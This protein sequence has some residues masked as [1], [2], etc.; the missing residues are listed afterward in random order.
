MAKPMTK[1]V[2]NEVEW[3]T[4][5]HVGNSESG[6]A[7]KKTQGVPESVMVADTGT[8]TYI[9]WAIPGTLSSAS[10]WRIARVEDATGSKLYADGDAFYNNIWDDRGDLIYS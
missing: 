3:E 8:Y 1:E 5:G 7:Y 9:G 10:G 2:I 4:L 6:E